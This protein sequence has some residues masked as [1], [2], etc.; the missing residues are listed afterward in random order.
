MKINIAAATTT[1]ALGVAGAFAMTGTA[2]AQEGSG[3]TCDT[4][5]YVDS[6][7]MGVGNCAG[8]PATDVDSTPFTIV[9]RDSGVRYRCLPAVSAGRAL[10]LSG[11]PVASAAVVGLMCVS[12]HQ[13][14]GD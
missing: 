11:V 2:Q 13:L 7:I 9:S 6:G 4:A 14:L 12:P 1:L 10:A 5:I 3:Y 8:T